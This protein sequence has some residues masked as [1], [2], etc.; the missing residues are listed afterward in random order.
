MSP[1]KMQTAFL[2]VIL[3]QY[4]QQLGWQGAFNYDFTVCRVFSITA[5]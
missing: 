1:Y 2:G 3:I 4:G 5:G